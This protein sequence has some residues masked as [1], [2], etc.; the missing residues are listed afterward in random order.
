MNFIYNF[1]VLKLKNKHLWVIEH[2][3]TFDAVKITRNDVFICQ[4][5]EIVMNSILQKPCIYAKLNIFMMFQ[6]I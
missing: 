6:A 3:K 4:F 1:F 2:E 5:E